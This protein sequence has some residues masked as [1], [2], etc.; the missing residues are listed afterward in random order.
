[1]Y[2]NWRFLDLYA[3]AG[4]AKRRMTCLP[5]TGPVSLKLLN[6]RSAFRILLIV[7][8]QQA[9]PVPPASIEHARDRYFSRM[10]FSAKYLTAPG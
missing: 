8:A 1:M 5:L 3:G 9:T 4:H 7:S 6:E 10:P 2:G